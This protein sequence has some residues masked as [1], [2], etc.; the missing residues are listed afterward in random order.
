VFGVP[1][2]GDLNGGMNLGYTGKPYDVVTGMYNYGY[3]DYK[4]EAARFTTEDPVRDGANWF[5]YVNNDPVNWVDLWGLSASDQNPRSLTDEEKVTYIQNYGHDIDFD[6]ITIIEGRLPTAQEVQNTAASVGI[7]PAIYPSEMLNN[8][9]EDPNLRAMA[10]PD[11]TIYSKYNPITADDLR[12]E[13][14]HQET[15]QNGATK[16]TGGV[17]K[18]F[19]TAGKVYKELINEALDKSVDPYKTPGYL[20]Y[21][22][23][24]RAPISQR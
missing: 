7:N 23:E 20:E 19:D 15:Y 5:A 21:Q 1:Y 14:N 22:A 6:K 17:T 2:E 4:P 16:T 9:L 11:G 13:L 12:H 10:L 24:Y 18:H 3:R 8:Y